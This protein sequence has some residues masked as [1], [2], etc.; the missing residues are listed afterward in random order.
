MLEGV[1]GPIPVAQ[2]S[3]ETSSKVSPEFFVAHKLA[4]EGRLDPPGSA[5]FR[6][7]APALKNMPHNSTLYSRALGVLAAASLGLACDAGD[8]PRREANSDAGPN[9]VELN[10]NEDEGRS[11]AQEE[12]EDS[13][14]EL[15]AIGYLDYADEPDERSE[16]PE[17]DGVV[18]HDKARAMEGWNL[19]VDIPA[20]RGILF[21]NDGVQVHQWQDEEAIRWLRCQLQ[22]NGDVIVLGV[23]PKAGGRPGGNDSYP[24]AYIARLTWDG[25]VLWR[26]SLPAH[27]DV[28]MTPRGDVLVLTQERRSAPQQTQ[29]SMRD[30]SLELFS[31]DGEFKRALSVYDFL[32]EKPELV[33]IARVDSLR[34]SMQ[35]DQKASSADEET[36]GDDGD[37]DS[38]ASSDGASPEHD[39]NSIAEAGKQAGTSLVKGLGSVLNPRNPATA[40]AVDLLHCNGVEWMPHGELT[41]LGEP[42]GENR[43][44]VTVRHQDLV[45]IVDWETSEMVWAW[46]QNQ[47][48]GPHEGT[49]L[50]N[51]NILIFD[52]GI[53]S[54]GYSRVLEVNPRN[55]EIVWEYQSDPPEK[56]FTKARGTAQELENGNILIASSGNGEAFEV[57]RSGEVVWRWLN[58]NR[59]E[60][61]GRASIRIT[62]Y[63]HAMLAE[64]LGSMS[65]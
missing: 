38:Q 13:F 12:A 42:Y 39:L 31:G 45:A 60:K 62:R 9:D 23:E 32:A 4:A 14:D 36:D 15:S 56:F 34:K 1:F 5:R 7:P 43:V 53:R 6:R 24:D 21:S 22:P 16:E 55:D 44:L 10:Q 41:A 63:P 54:R 28:E 48:E 18:Q 35:A 8:A 46:G 51:G 26:N 57:T 27:H 2:G 61:G 33:Q 59:G 11:R 40:R 17:G 50:R 37:Q 30:N 64:R 29:W 19:V 3:G 65:K 47:L 25:E 49:W 58:P 52:N 20:G